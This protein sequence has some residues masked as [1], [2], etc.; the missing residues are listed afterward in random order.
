MI[1]CFAIVTAI[2]VLLPY[3]RYLTST[4]SLYAVLAS[5]VAT[6]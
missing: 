6:K 5:Y 2:L 4:R 3:H 1:A